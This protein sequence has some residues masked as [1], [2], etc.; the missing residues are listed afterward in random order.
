MGIMRPKSR[1]MNTSPGHSSRKCCL[2]SLACAISYVQITSAAYLLH[3]DTLNQGGHTEIELPENE[4]KVRFVWGPSSVSITEAPER[5]NEDSV[6]VTT[7]APVGLDGALH[8]RQRHARSSYNVLSGEIRIADNRVRSGPP[9]ESGDFTVDLVTLVNQ[10]QQSVSFFCEDHSGDGITVRLSPRFWLTVVPGQ[11]M[12]L[13]ESLDTS[14]PMSTGVMVGIACGATIIAVI[15]AVVIRRQIVPHAAKP[16]PSQAASSEIQVRREAWLQRESNSENEQRLL[17]ILRTFREQT[18]SDSDEQAST[19]HSAFT[20]LE[21]PSPTRTPGVDFDSPHATPGSNWQWLSA[22]KN[23]MGSPNNKRSVESRGSTP[24]RTRASPH[25][26]QH[27]GIS[28]WQDGLGF[29][30][31]SVS[32]PTRPAWSPVIA[33]AAAEAEPREPSYVGGRISSSGSRGPMSN[34]REVFS[35]MSNRREVFSPLGARRGTSGSQQP[36]TPSSMRRSISG[37][38]HRTQEEAPLPA[39]DYNDTALDEL[40]FDSNEEK[41]DELHK[42]LSRFQSVAGSG[43]RRTDT[44]FAVVRALL[45][46]EPA[47]YD[48]NALAFT[49]GDVIYVIQKHSNGLW[50]GAVLDGKGKLGD[51]GCF[52]FTIVDEI[53]PAEYTDAIKELRQQL[54]DDQ[55]ISLDGTLSPREV[56]LY[57]SP[58]RARSSSQV[59]RTPVPKRENPLFNPFDSPEPS[60]AGR[61]LSTLS[62]SSFT[63]IREIS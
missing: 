20:D 26:P 9:S 3:W 29:S 21:T 41:L 2:L 6:D 56:P 11:S 57:P 24:N 42:V 60:P 10:T 25:F 27:R 12:R 46:R 37:T 51:K 59:G 47:S 13:T 50:E 17:D 35:P 28:A 31:Q 23:W 45:D 8:K 53:D 43:G 36:T 61:R 54:M 40:T 32:S 48:K 30:P 44:R 52:P 5:G 55:K 1:T 34:R 4:N 58:I 19:R 7:A 63:P 18:Y 22:V 38:R 39:Y 16:D 33:A 49:K 62:N 14:S 15:A